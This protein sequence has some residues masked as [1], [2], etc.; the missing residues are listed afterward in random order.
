MRILQVI[1]SMRSGGAE[2]LITL[3]APRMIAAGHDV[4]VALFDGIDTHLK[5]ALAD[6]GVTVHSL[7]VGGSV[8]NPLLIGRL[9]KLARGFDIV[10]THNTSPQL[11]AA[12]GTV[13]LNVRLVTTE[14]NT[15]NRRR[16]I[17][18]FTVIDRW[19]YGRYNHI[20][21]ISDKA[22]SYLRDYLGD[23]KV[24]ISTIYNGIDLKQIH[25]ATGSSVLEEIAPRSRKILM[26]AGFRPQKDQDTLIRAIRLLPD[27]F[28]LFLAGD[29]VRRHDLESLV[30]ECDVADRVHFLGV[31]DDVP[32]LIKSTDYIVMSSHYE[33]LSL[34]SVEGMASG[35]PFLAS[36]VD[37]L[38]EVVDGAGVL[39]E[40]ENSRMLA[41]KINELD[42]NKIL[43][44]GVSN[45][46]QIHAQQYDIDKM[47]EGYVGVYNSLMRAKIATK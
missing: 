18:G 27:D 28:H 46:C 10:H 47:V 24:N 2:K 34:A 35:K 40:H 1:T 39:F 8:Y 22:E 12:L 11:F 37:G 21:C 45:K 38:H 26:V 25:E 19:M 6:S 7:S 44:D 32:A 33:G 17:P 41:D 20:I 23:E 5:Q 4:E 30:R 31:R 16:H 3:I 36:D 15:N 29:G 43:Y 13:G 42:T 14:H 9:R